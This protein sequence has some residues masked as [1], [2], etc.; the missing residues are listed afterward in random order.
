MP[1]DSPKPVNYIPRTRNYY[2]ALGYE[3]DYIWAKH[4]ESPF[5]KL[6]KPISQSRL[7]IITTAMPD[8]SMSGKARSVCTQTTITPPLEMYTDELAWDKQATHTQDVAS[9]LPIAQCQ[10]YVEDGFLGSLTELFYCIPSEYS[11]RQTIEVDAPAI[12]RGCIEQQADIALLV[13]L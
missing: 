4:A 9:F 2:R 5:S 13:P 11:Q 10:R 6:K 1:N 12:V 7:A 8:D 3:K